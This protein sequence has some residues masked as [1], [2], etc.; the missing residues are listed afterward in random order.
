MGAL[1]TEVKT[2]LSS[3][4]KLLR[5]IAY[6]V[7][8]S[9][10]L[11]LCG[12]M[13]SPDRT[14]FIDRPEVFT[15]ERL[16]SR[17]VEEQQ[18]LEDKLDD[19]VPA[20]GYHGLREIREFAG[21]YGKLGI[22]FDPLQG[23][24]DTARAET[25]LQQ[26][27]TNQQIGALQTELSVMQLRQQIRELQ[28]KIEAGQYHPPEPN[29]VRQDTAAAVTNDQLQAELKKL[30]K[31][32]SAKTEDAIAKLKVD[33]IFQKTSGVAPLPSAAEPNKT[34]AV[35]HP[36]DRL[37]DEQAYRSAVRAAL[38]EQELDDTHDLL[39]STIYTLKFDVS[40]PSVVE[41][42]DFARV[43]F[44]MSKVHSLSNVELIY[45]RWVDGLEREM[46]IEVQS[47]YNL[48]RSPHMTVNERLIVNV[49]LQEARIREEKDNRTIH[50]E[51]ERWKQ[52][53]SP[54]PLGAQPFNRLNDEPPRV[55]QQ[56]RL[57]TTATG[58]STQRP[59]EYKT[60]LE[61]EIKKRTANIEALESLSQKMVETRSTKAVCVDA[62]EGKILH[63]YV[64]SKYA[65]LAKYIAFSEP[66]RMGRDSNG[67]LYL[68]RIDRDKLSCRNRI[69]AFEG[70][71]KRLQDENPAYVYVVEPGIQAQ[72]IS[73]VAAVEN[74]KNF[75][76]SAQALL[77]SGVTA[78]GYLE[79]IRR[80]R[81]TLH[82][83][84]RIPLV[85]G[86][87][88]SKKEQ[89]AV[90]RKT[91]K[92]TVNRVEQFGWVFGPG[93]EIGKDNEVV[94]RFSGRPQPVQVSLVVPAW[95]DTIKLGVTK[96]WVDSRYGEKKWWGWLRRW[97][98]LK[99][100]EFPGPLDES[101]KGDMD[102]R[103]PVDYTALTNAL[104]ELSGHYR[105]APRIDLP[106]PADA[107][108]PAYTLEVRNDETPQHLVIR[109]AELWRNPR[110]FVGSA[111]A[112]GFE[113]L[114]DM[115]GL[116][117]E[118]KNVAEPPDAKDGAAVVDLRIVTSQ[119]ASV[120]EK[121]VKII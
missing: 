59:A 83:I 57:R 7:V 87:A 63:L 24:I 26:A 14:I 119:G 1:I 117:V 89:G 41:T 105:R 18:F 8:A 10:L 92:K 48:L 82:A 84:Q 40:I 12:C 35:I 100:S 47:V 99:E 88:N 111:E 16:L 116:V 90:D 69:K 21:L 5:L 33:S 74:L 42:R 30:E 20:T 23:K 81:E 68:P 95:W 114:P 106:Y 44:S 56:I 108:S 15:R 76:L 45:N 22:R 70:D 9:V 102:V 4:R 34:K 31:D 103:L 120:R 67:Y 77:S 97:G 121:A 61:D 37:R 115:Q 29:I 43:V 50:E 80:T 28:Q 2:F 60:A 104:L 49:G 64:Q 96:S 110:V 98:P 101:D 25:V 66:L 54:S 109:G 32:L 53:T 52:Q 39:G 46:W 62:N 75:V 93:F 6:M 51:L 118:F 65:A 19:P 79:S 27:K 38:L 85:V 78:D 17:R 91:N 71:L 112:D 36:I 11:S 113:I 3:Q 73:E 55:I 107:N 86:F 58:D 72:N 13:P 94:R